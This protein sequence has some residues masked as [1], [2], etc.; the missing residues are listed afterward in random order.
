MNKACS[1]KEAK[2]IKSILTRYP[3]PFLAFGSRVKGS[4][5]T[6]SDLD[7]CYQVDIPDSVIAGLMDDFEQSDL[8]FKVDIV[9]WKRCSPEFQQMI[10]DD[11][12]PLDVLLQVS[13]P[14]KS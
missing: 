8:P 2:I 14:N 4:C 5:K 10:Q 9:A 12:V 13:S 7:L 6:F 3:Y 11:L 1:Q